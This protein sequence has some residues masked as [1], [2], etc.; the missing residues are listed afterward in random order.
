MSPPPAE[1]AAT[2]P[3]MV[4]FL[5]TQQGVYPIW[6]RL[7]NFI[8]KTPMT[9]T[10]PTI[11]RVRFALRN[12]RRKAVGPDGSPGCL[13]SRL[14]DEVITIWLEAF[15]GIATGKFTIPHDFLLAHT[16]LLFKG[17]D[18]AVPAQW[19]PIAL[20]NTTFKAFAK[21]LLPELEEFVELQTEWEQHGFLKKKGCPLLA[22]DLVAYLQKNPD[23]WVFFA[24]VEKAYPSVHHEQL[25]DLLAR[26]GLSL[27]THRV[28]SALYAHPVS[29]AMLP[30][31]LSREYLEKRG[32]PTLSTALCFYV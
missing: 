10:P 32:V 28:I 7:T 6:E 8:K 21:L 25:L 22:L 20:L 9:F 24:D 19:R 14:P 3:A 2:E 27:E 13:L 29:R 4:N 15:M 18:P 30:N 1:V 12:K 16:F 23:S 11:D 5:S 17:G 26:S 31:G